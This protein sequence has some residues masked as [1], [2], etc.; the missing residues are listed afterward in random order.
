M[1]H[2]AVRAGVVVALLLIAAVGATPADAQVSRKTLPP[3]PRLTDRVAATASQELTGVIL[4]GDGQPLKGAVVSALGAA[5]AYGLSDRDGRF[6]LRNLPHGSYVLRVHLHGYVPA[7]SR[8]VQLASGVRGPL[9]IT[10][11]K[12]P[13]S[14]DD[15]PEVLDAG[16]GPV[17]L[18]DDDVEETE[19]HDHAE[20]S[21]RLRH[22]RRSVLKEATDHVALGD[23]EPVQSEAMIAGLGWAFEGSA[24]LASALI[25]DLDLNGQFNF[26][27]STSLDRPQDLFSAYGDM[28][29]GV[30]FLSLVAP[31]DGGEWRMR[32]TVTQGD[33]S[34][35]IVSGA[36][37]RKAGAVHAYETGVSYAMQR[38]LGGN[39]EALVALRDG[40]RNVGTLYAYDHWTVSP[41]LQLSYGARY[42]DYDYLDDERLFSPRARVVVQPT[43]D[44][45]FRVLA[46]ASRS[47]T[48]PG[49]VEFLPPVA[50]V[51]L[52][53]E[54]TFSSLGESG[55]VSQ[56]VD[57]VEAGLEQDFGP[58]IVSTRFFKQ[59][60]TD[61]VVGVFGSHLAS[62]ATRTG[63]YYVGSAGDFD[64]KGW[65]V[66]AESPVGDHTRASVDYQQATAT[67]HRSL[68]PTSVSVLVP[69]SIR[70]AADRVH[71]VAASVES[72]VAPTDTRLLV[73][74]RLSTARS[75]ADPDAA[76]GG[77]RFEVQ[78]NQALPFLA[79]ANAKWEA[80]VAVRNMFYGAN[81]AT[82]LYDEIL[83]VRP[84]TRV[85]GGVTVKF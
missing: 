46:S 44:R 82:S 68:R 77:S 21:W 70:R 79:F 51:W 81:G 38:Y 67:W 2:S 6:V 53:P 20:V 54:R 19:T 50:G 73:I 72:T 30:A 83:V 84:P 1:H 48:A 42:A 60:A 36:F 32:G 31:S 74:Y 26:L 57:H 80:L 9:S 15:P 41:R 11:Q 16:V 45:T 66:S 61:Q 27:T 23:H 62:A 14:P 40:S 24:R 8:V 47:E 34:S 58:L 69:D 12:R 22:S 4:D 33:L 63:H 39:A 52:P 43:S 65:G 78:I 35:W 76:A 5:S 29:R 64:A 71:S 28:P 13:V 49:A 17:D 10:M 59:S 55:L 56:R 18:R 7:R 25:P 37:V 75:V 85:L 3:A